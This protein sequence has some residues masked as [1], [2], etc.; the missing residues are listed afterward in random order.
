MVY[1]RLSASQK[2]CTKENNLLSVRRK[3]FLRVCLT[4]YREKMSLNHNTLYL[5]KVA[6]NSC[7]N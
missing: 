2:H 1:F 3:L 4:N 6:R 5:E 7:N